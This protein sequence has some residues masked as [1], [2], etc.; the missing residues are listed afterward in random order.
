MQTFVIF[1]LTLERIFEDILGRGGVPMPC[2]AFCCGE[3]LC[4]C[5][6]ACVCLCVV[7]CACVYEGVVTS[8]F[9]K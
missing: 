9:P 6:C 4:V 7:W 8:N 2:A 1:A 3:C 5:V